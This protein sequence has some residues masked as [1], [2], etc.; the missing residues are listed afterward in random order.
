MPNAWMVRA[1]EA[2]YRF[3]QCKQGFVAIGWDDI[4]D[5]APC[6]G[7]DAIR[8]RYLKTYPEQK[9]GEVRNGV[10]VIAKFRFDIAVGDHVMTYSPARREYLVGRIT[11]EYQ[12]DPS[13]IPGYPHLRTVQWGQPISRD[14]LH[15][16][17]R[18]SLGSA[19]TLFA[20][21]EDIWEDVRAA[22]HRSSRAAEGP[23]EEAEKEAIRQTK[24]DP[25]ERSR[26]LIKD[27]VARLTEDD[28][29]ELAAALLRAMG[30]RARVTPKGPDRGGE[31]RC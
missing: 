3:D 26:E 4:G 7:S 2:G 20:L 29:E 28:M 19:L 22:Q 16:A 5:L 10:A 30:Y 8:S 12:D 11:G 9:P 24:E 21:G 15:P 13:R 1:G 25:I 27:Q 14:S 6:T 17:S 18:N 31:P 23:R